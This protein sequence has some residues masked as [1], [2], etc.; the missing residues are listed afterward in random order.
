[1]HDMGVYFM[2]SSQFPVKAYMGGKMRKTG[3]KLLKEGLADMICSDAHSLRSYDCLS[4]AFEMAQKYGY[5]QN[6]A[7]QIL[8]QCF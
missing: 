8:S 7:D 6:R 4:T 5:D 2:L 1:M 3:K